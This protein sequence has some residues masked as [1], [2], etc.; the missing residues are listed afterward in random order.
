MGIQHFQDLFRIQPEVIAYDLHPDYMATRYA[1]DRA[2]KEGLPA[3]GV[4]HHHAHIA[5]CMAEHKLSGD[6]PVIGVS[7]DGTGYGTDGIHL[8]RRIPGGRL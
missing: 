3:I 5:A 2:E 7:F 4:Q 6:R 8:G 1:L